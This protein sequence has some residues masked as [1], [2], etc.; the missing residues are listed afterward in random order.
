MIIDRHELTRASK[1]FIT[2]AESLP[3]PLRKKERSKNIWLIWAWESGYVR[4]QCKHGMSINEDREAIYIL[5][6]LR[7]YF[8]PDN[9]DAM[10]K[11]LLTC[12]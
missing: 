5:T 6:K 4:K 2:F 7:E 9:E 12:I 8:Y 11:T 10:S 3:R 1:E